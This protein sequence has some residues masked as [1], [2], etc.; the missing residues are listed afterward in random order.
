MIPVT[1]QDN[2]NHRESLHVLRGDS[3]KAKLSEAL[4]GKGLPEGLGTPADG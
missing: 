2:E 1:K 4:S 3:G